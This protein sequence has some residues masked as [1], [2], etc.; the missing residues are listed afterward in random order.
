MARG[1]REQ[2]EIVFV[3]FVKVR[4]S[5]V[6][7]AFYF[8]ASSTELHVVCRLA[9]EV[10][11]F[12]V[13]LLLYVHIRISAVAIMTTCSSLLM[14]TPLVDFVFNLVTTFTLGSYYWPL[15]R[16]DLYRC[17]AENKNKEPSLQFLQPEGF[18]R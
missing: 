10:V 12:S 16:D 13:G 2:V 7:L 9:Y 15:S 1:T 8:V 6:R 4:A 3:K 5:L 17:S 11:F 14:N 18:R